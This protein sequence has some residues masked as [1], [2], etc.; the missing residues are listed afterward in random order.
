MGV[1][2]DIRNFAAKYY[3]LVLQL[4]TYCVQKFPRFYRGNFFE[5]GVCKFV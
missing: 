3:T 1:P 4:H 5:V 2:K